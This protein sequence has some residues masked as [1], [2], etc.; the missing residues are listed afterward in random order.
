LEDP[1]RSD[2][3]AEGSQF[4]VVESL[5][6][7]IGV[8]LNCL[9][10]NLTSRCSWGRRLVAAQQSVQS[11]AQARL[12]LGIHERPSSR[13]TAPPRVHSRGLY[14]GGSAQNNRASF[15]DRVDR[16]AQNLS[17]DRAILDHPAR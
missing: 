3:G 4:V 16:S 5:A 12:L 8:L 9:D 13:R 11:T 15:A 7:L 17:E 2:A 10:P 6:R 14:Q 1:V